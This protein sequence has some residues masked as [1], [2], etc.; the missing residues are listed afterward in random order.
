M[1]AGKDTT[2][3]QFVREVRT[4]ETDLTKRLDIL[5]GDPKET[6]QHPHWVEF[7]QPGHLDF[8]DEGCAEALGLGQGAVDH[9]NDDW[10]ADQKEL[11][12]A[13]IQKA[14]ESGFSVQFR[15]RLVDSDKE[16]TYVEVLEDKFLITFLAPREKTLARLRVVREEVCR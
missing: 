2:E 7:C 12:R 1:P 4:G 8:I 9:L 15:W 6:V 16:D 13:A 5:C 3:A 10:P 11:G 14:L